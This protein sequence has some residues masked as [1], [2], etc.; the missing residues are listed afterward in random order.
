M[1]DAVVTVVGVLASLSPSTYRRL[2][3]RRRPWRTRH[4]RGFRVRVR[5]P[6]PPKRWP[7]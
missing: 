3:R 6:Y 7:L 2:T 5:L 4:R 1:N